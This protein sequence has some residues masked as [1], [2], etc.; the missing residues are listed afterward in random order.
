MNDNDPAEE[1]RCLKK[2]VGKLQRKLANSEQNRAR[3]ELHMDKN[4]S[5]FRA[6]ILE[7]HA[8]KELAESAT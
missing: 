3:L 6:T 5:L 1:I 4:N 7:L 2:E 8:A